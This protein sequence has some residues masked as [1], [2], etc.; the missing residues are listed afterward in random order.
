MIF[1]TNIF[2]NKQY[3]RKSL[4]IYFKQN[5]I[6]NLIN[7]KDNQYVGTNHLNFCPNSEI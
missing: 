5:N 1:T 6:Q 7:F 4:K 2:I 3:E